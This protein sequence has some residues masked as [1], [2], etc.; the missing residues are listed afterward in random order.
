M[1]QPILGIDIAKDT[2]AVCLLVGTQKG[3]T[4]FE[5]TP[6]GFK[7]LS[8][9]LTQHTLE[10]LHACMEATG[11]YGEGLAEYLY[12]SGAQVSVV[13]PARIKAYARCQL[14]RNK[15][16]KADAALI[17]LYCAREQPALWSPPPVAFKDLQALVRRWDDLQAVYQQERNRLQAGSHPAAVRVDLQTHLQELKG[18]LDRLEQA[19]QAHIQAH[20]E[21]KRRQALLVSIPGIGKRTAAHLLGEIRDIIEF[22]T[23]RQLAAYAGLTP[24]NCTSGSSVSQKPRLSK[25]GNALVR[26]A[27]YMPAVVAKRFNPIIRAFCERMLA[28]GHAPMQIIGAAMRKLLHLVYGVLKSGKPFDPH[29]LEPPLIAA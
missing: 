29:F 10:P 19:I 23:A 15:T 27:L 9:W 7:A 26:K 17:A 1:S 21:L 28:K 14:R 11:R 24:R 22:A 4:S 8:H 20:A 12:Q 5:N 18:H 13:N 16:D 3:Q 2:F 6:S 25:T